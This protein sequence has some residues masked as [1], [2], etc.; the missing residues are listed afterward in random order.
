[1]LLRLKGDEPFSVRT[2]FACFFFLALLV[3]AGCGGGGNQDVTSVPTWSPARATLIPP[4]TRLPVRETA[5]PTVDLT[6]TGKDV[7]LAPLPLQA[8][9]L[10]TITVLV[11]NNAPAPAVGIPVMVYLTAD[12]DQIGFSSFFEV[13]TATLPATQ[14][15]AV[16]FPVAWNLAG[17]GHQL[18]VQ[19]NNLPTAWQAR[20]PTSLEAD[21]SD[22]SV[23]LELTIAPFDAYSSDLCAG[24][25]DVSLEAADVRLESDLQHVRVRVR[26]LG[27][28]AVYNLPVVVVGKQV[29]GVGYTP[30][31]PPCGGT[32]EVVVS[33]DTTDGQPELGETLTVEVNPKDWVDG[34]AED[35]F[36]NNRVALLVASPQAD[37]SGDSGAPAAAAPS[38]Y[39][40]ALSPA[41]VELTRPGLLLIKVHNLGTR[42]AASVPI[43]L[44]GKAGRKV[45]DVVPLV[46]GEGSGMVAISL[47][48]LWTSQATLT[49]TV[50]AEGAKGSYPEADRDNNVVTFTLP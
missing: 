33:L 46:E 35:R 29:T 43:R 38:E 24:R 3:L 48:W 16:Q 15:V 27:N 2:F 8:G 20:T 18:W 9:S 4:V 22:N 28:L 23:L 32:A 19:V 41:D 11:H 44:E 5:T 45:T 34:L 42:D 17:G 7:K 25:V 49:I 39:D 1:M 14:T 40:F 31:L 6:V 37:S 47:G 10:F 12:L 36:D 21:L 26:N 50:N 30:A 13:L